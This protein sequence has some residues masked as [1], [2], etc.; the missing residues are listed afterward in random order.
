MERLAVTQKMAW[1]HR[2]RENATFWLIMATSPPVSHLARQTHPSTWRRSSNGAILR[3]R[4]ETL[5]DDYFYI[6]KSSTE[7]TLDTLLHTKHTR[8]TTVFHCT[9]GE[10]REVNSG[11]LELVEKL[12]I[13]KVVYVGIIPPGRN[14]L[15][16]MGL[17]VDPR[18]QCLVEERYVLEFPCDPLNFASEDTK[19]LH[20]PN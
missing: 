5:D 8:T 14:T 12:G 9:D 3:G 20:A 19:I 7:A 4:F 13:E 18:L 16:K 1:A 10:E 6:S 17:D 2:S 15:F 11:E